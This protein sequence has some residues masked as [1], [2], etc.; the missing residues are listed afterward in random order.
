MDSFAEH[1]HHVLALAYSRDGSSLLSTLND[2][3]HCISSVAY[4]FDVPRI[5]SGSFERRFLFGM[6]K[7]VKLFMD[8]EYLVSKKTDEDSDTALTEVDFEEQTAGYQA[9]YSRLA[10]SESPKVD[11]VAYVRDAQQYFGQELTSFSKTHGEQLRVLLELT[12]QIL[13]GAFL[14]G[15]VNNT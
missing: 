13:T 1:E 14:K 6:L 5:V 10:A 15:L 3:S 7:V 4:P 2:Y 12:D 11:P 9:A 8:P